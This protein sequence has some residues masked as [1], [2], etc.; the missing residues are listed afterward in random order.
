[1]IVTTT[2]HVEG[3]KAEEYLGICAGEAIVGANIVRDMSASVRDVVGAAPAVM[4][5]CWPLH[6]AVRWN[7][8]KPRSANGEPMP[9]SGCH[10]TTKW[11]ARKVRC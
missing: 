5:R 4:K 1:M 6:A 11:G 2:G 3:R 7:P 8:S 10:S 9:S